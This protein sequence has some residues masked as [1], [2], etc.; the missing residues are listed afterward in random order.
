MTTV[1]RDGSPRIS[2]TEVVLDEGAPVRLHDAGARR[3]AD[4]QRD[5]RLALHSHSADPPPDDPAG[6]PGEAKVTVRAVAD[7]RR[8][9][10]KSTAP[11]STSP[12]R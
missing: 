9:A 4:V 6:W 5:P 8:P 2:G 11:G 12:K 3:A 10:L 7:D 1:R